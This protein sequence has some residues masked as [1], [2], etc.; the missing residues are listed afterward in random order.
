MTASITESQLPAPHH[1]PPLHAHH[2]GGGELIHVRRR[3]VRVRRRKKESRERWGKRKREGHNDDNFYSSLTKTKC[4]PWQSAKEDDNI[5]RGITYAIN[6]DER[7]KVEHGEK[8]GE[9]KREAAVVAW[10][11]QAVKMKTM[12]KDQK[13]RRECCASWI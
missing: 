5:G 11:S 9:E 8:G 6:K 1:T 12:I 2:V 4:R 7:E 13:R 3:G 10:S